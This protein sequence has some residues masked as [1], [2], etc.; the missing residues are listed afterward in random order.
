MEITFAELVAQGDEA[1]SDGTVEAF[2]VQAV[3]SGTLN[4][5]GTPYNATTNNT[6]DASTPAQW[7][8]ATVGNAQNAFT[9]VAQ[10]NDG[11]VSVTP[12]P[13][14]VDVTTTIFTEDFNSYSGNQNGTQSDT[15]LEV[16]H[17]GN[18][19]GWT[20][21]GS[22]TIHA[23]DLANL[24]G[25]SN[26]SDWAV[27]FFQNNVITQ[28]AGI[29]ANEVGKSYDVTFDYGTGVYA[30]LSQ[31]TEATDSLLV[32]VLRGD[33]SVL[34]SD[35]FTPGAWGAG[36]HNLDAGLQGTL[37]YTGDGTGNVRLRIGPTAPLT[38]GNFEGEI[39][40]LTVT[41]GAAPTITGTVVGQ[42][43]DDNATIQPFTG[44]TI[45]DDD[46]DSLDLTVTLDVAA[47][48]TLTGGGFTE[49]GSW[50]G[51]LHVECGRSGRG[52]HRHS[53][54]DVHAHRKSGCPRQHGAHDIHRFG[55]RQ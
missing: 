18:V 9:V 35:T 14:T 22:G 19:A 36:N 47:N 52:D 39:D 5:G 55:R 10:D 26:P 12:V 49:T 24:G 45:A 38:S 51:H 15:G 46:G 23:V 6:I 25:Q 41:V 42:N 31:M 48:G 21:A 3:T 1:D 13:V 54:P 11:D 2:V 8:T 32:E 28:A 34:A 4:I 30:Q 53:G 43:V 7:T 40:N 20:N 17:T 16:A 44:V 37:S 27:M 29:A 50:H 33:N